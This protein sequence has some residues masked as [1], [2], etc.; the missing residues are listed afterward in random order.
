MDST[1][2]LSTKHNR[3]T[4]CAKLPTRSII[5]GPSGSGKSV[6]L[7]NMVMDM[8]KGCFD[9]AFIISPTIHIDKFW[10]PV[11]HYMTN[12]LNMNPEKEH[13]FMDSLLPTKACREC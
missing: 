4:I 1:E 13:C 2:K 3:Y 11:K 8:K 12:V 10:E 5:L 7:Q 9:K 6:L